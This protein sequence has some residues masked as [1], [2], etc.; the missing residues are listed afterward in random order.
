MSTTRLSRGTWDV[1]D[2]RML[3]VLGRFISEERDWVIWEG[4]GCCRAS[5]EAKGE[6]RVD[7][8]GTKRSKSVWPS[9]RTGCRVGAVEVVDG[10]EGW[11]F[12]Q[13]DLSWEEAV[14]G[15]VRAVPSVAADSECGGWLHAA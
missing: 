7:T 2:E 13:G 8:R 4:S 11:H 12:E 5:A 9:E 10:E 6:K 1:A 3:E 15:R 14:R